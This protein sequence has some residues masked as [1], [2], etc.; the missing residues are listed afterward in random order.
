[1]TFVFDTRPP[2]GII[3]LSY[4]DDSG[5]SRSFIEDYEDLLQRTTETL[6]SNLALLSKLKGVREAIT[7]ALS[8]GA[9]IADVS[10]S[11]LP[12]VSSEVSDHI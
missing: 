5:N 12:T 7:T 2:M 9:R 1:M 6:E 10:N 4:D 8:V 3:T 11:I